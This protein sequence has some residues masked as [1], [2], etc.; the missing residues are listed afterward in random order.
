MA[1]DYRRAYVA[2]WRMVP[3]AFELLEALHPHAP[4]GIVS[5]NVVGEQIRED[6]LLRAPAVSGH[7]RHL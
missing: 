3:G 4:V 1:A 6:S 2:A 7:R 5:N